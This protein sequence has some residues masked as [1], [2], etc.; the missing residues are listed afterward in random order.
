MIKIIDTSKWQNS[1]VDYAAAKRAGYDG[2]I[3][4]VGAS[5]HKD[6]CFERDYE[7][8]K[9]AGMLIGV[10]YYT[11]STTEV[12]ALNDATRVLR[13]LANRKLD[14]PV[15]YD[16]EDA[17]QKSA[18]RK[19]INSKMYNAFANRIKAHYDTMLY[20]GEYFFNNY[21]DK[22]AIKDKLWIAKYSSKEPNVGRDIYMWQ[23]TSDAFVDDFYKDKLDRSYLYGA[24]FDT[25]LLT[26][27]HNPFKVPKKNV[28]KGSSGE[29]A[30][31]VQW[32]LWRFGLI[33]KEQITGF[34]DEKCSEAIKVAQ[35]RLGLVV[36]GIVGKKSK[37]V[38]L[39]VC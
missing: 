15:A 13:W 35:L 18:G 38:F 11:Y 16:I 34:I 24:V 37:E 33:T 14:L 20:T 28:L 8:A 25:S 26:V 6:V 22:S 30:L 2:V 36:D 3:L 39:Q 27:D 1:E 10:Y 31:W 32:Y 5:S 29:D 21:F 7:N 19:I 9:K 17:K 23:Y 4:R 12:Q